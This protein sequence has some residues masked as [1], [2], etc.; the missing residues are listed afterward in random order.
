MDLSRIDEV[1]K[2]LSALFERINSLKTENRGLKQEIYSLKTNLEQTRISAAS[3]DDIRRKFS[4]LA[5][6]RE[7]LMME[8]ELIRSKVK[9]ALEKIDELIG[10][11]E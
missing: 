8:R 11:E 3:S 5:G 6:E 4:G 10:E 7:S 1:E 9:T 2:K